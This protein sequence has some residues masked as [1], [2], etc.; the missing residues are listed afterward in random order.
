[1]AGIKLCPDCG[2]ALRL[3]KEHVWLDN[4]TIVQRKNPDHR[5]VFF[6]IENV[7]GTFREI[8]R[9][10]GMSLERI[11]V[12][13]K[14]RATFDFISKAYPALVKWVVRA[15]VG[16]RPVIKSI[17]SLGK[18]MG[19]GNIQLKSVRRIH[20][21][22][23]YVTILVENPYCLELFCGDLV[24]SFEAIDLREASA[25]YKELSPGIYEVT[26]VV[27]R[28]PLELMERLKPRPY[29]KK[30]G[31]IR[32]E[33]CPGCGG[34]MGLRYFRWDTDKGMI[35][36]RDTGWR[37]A[38]FGPAT[39]DAI[40][41]ELEKELGEEI[42]RVV[43]E[44]QRRFVKSGVMT[45]RNVRSFGDFRAQMALRGLGNVVHFQVDEKGLSM[46]V[47]NPCMHLLLAGLSLGIYE[48]TFDSE[49]EVDWQLDE[50]GD[51][52]I[53]VRAGA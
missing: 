35:V 29:S 6:E 44:A 30:P 10:I 41:E 4:G 31:D 47:E 27:S 25:T 1:M 14:R 26:G 43:V 28:H 13:A 49:G 5:M 42:P 19:Y 23:D 52:H 15:L 51:L 37:M 33:R 38:M 32:L 48:V 8:E 2:A 11:I 24:G 16:L 53:Q 3:V 40:F 17:N 36:H 20:G 50:E 45:A 39:I 21:K 46:R 34:P 9:L 18:V 22:G 7:V 12:E